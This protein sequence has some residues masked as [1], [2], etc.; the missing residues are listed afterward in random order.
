MVVGAVS[1]MWS[2]RR[3]IGSREQEGVKGKT[4]Q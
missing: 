1:L 4:S 3:A 2:W